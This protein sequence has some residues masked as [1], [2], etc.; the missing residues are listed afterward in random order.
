M[1]CLFLIIKSEELYWDLDAVRF[2][3]AAALNVRF[4]EERRKQ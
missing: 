3:E 1:Y 2:R 4:L